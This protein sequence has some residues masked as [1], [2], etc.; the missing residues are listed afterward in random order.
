MRDKFL[1]RLTGGHRISIQINKN[2]N[3]KREI[4]METVEAKNINTSYYKSLY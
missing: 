2:R 3:K 1:I 4:T